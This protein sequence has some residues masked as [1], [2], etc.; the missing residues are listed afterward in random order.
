MQ[1]NAAAKAANQI[2]FIP[3]QR[4]PFR[5]NIVDNGDRSK[6]LNKTIARRIAFYVRRHKPA[7]LVCCILGNEYNAVGLARHPRP[8][9]FYF[10][11]DPDLPTDTNAELITLSTF[12][13]VARQRLEDFKFYLETFSRS[14]SLPIISVPPPPPVP[15]AEHIAAHPSMFASAIRNL[16]ISPAYLR[17]KIWK[18]FV[19]AQEQ[20]C[21]DVGVRFHRLPA[22]VF[23]SSGCL[24]KQYWNAD[25]THG[26]VEYGKVI[27][28]DIIAAS[29][30][31]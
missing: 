27:L 16:G 12:E 2:V 18:V 14:V 22:A 17:L 29:G 5:P 10:P 3:L 28:S 1:R 8:F 21:Q 19:R 6:E 15:D 9:D 11:S 31:G 24:A 7:A 23:D 20:I 30:R 25:P 4:P 13:E 26:N